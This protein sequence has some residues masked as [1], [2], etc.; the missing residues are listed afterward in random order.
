MG[1]G[2]IEGE[3]LYIG[4]EGDGVRIERL[5]IVG[6]CGAGTAF[7]AAEGVVVLE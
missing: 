6:G 4:F 7:G 1:G 5:T 3:I 2:V